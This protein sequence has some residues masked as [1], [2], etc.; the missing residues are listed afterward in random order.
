MLKLEITSSPAGCRKGANN[1]LGIKQINN[2]VQQI[3]THILHSTM[4]TSLSFLVK[5]NQAYYIIL[6]ASTAL[7][8]QIV[9]PH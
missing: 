4:G 3:P 9:L 1:V 8:Y 5:Q 6:P 2:I 7:H